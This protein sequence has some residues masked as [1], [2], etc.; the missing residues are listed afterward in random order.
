[1]HQVAQL[2]TA[3]GSES[4]Y[5]SRDVVDVAYVNVGELVPSASATS[6]RLQ[7]CTI[8]AAVIAPAGVNDWGVHHTIQT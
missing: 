4:A 6:I 3:R 1:M 8:L 7:S 5:S 2:H